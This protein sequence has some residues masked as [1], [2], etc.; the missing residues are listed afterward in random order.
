MTHVWRASAARLRQAAISVGAVIALAVTGSAFAA[1]PVIAEKPDARRTVTPQDIMAL[2]DVSDPQISPDGR[3]VLYV[4][5]TRL[6]TGNPDR[7]EIRIAAVDRKR[8][9]DLPRRLTAGVSRE[10]SPRWSPDGSTI[11]FLSDLA[12]APDGAAL[13]AGGARQLWLVSRDGSAPRVLTRAKGG[14]RSF[15][16]SPDGGSIAF[17]SV[18]AAGQAPEQG[19]QANA[20]EAS[21]VGTVLDL[22][23]PFAR[24]WIKDLASGTERRIAVPGRHIA[25]L[26]WSPDARHFA[27]RAAASSG[28]NDHFYHSELLLLDARTGAVERKLSDSVYSTASWSPDGRL[29]AFTAPGPGPIGILAYIA[30]PATGQL[31]E[32]GQNFA[33]TVR[34]L[35]WS[36]KADTIIARVTMHTRQQ[37]FRVDPASGRFFPLV[38]FDGRI[39]DFSI[40]EDGTLAL[41]A[42]TPDRPADVWAGR[43]DRLR[44]ITD[45]NPQVR[46]LKLAKVSE[47]H[48]TSSQ[49]GRPIYGVQVLPPGYI[50]GRPAKTVVLAHGGPHDSWSAAWQGS[51]I[52]WAQILAARGYVILLPNPRGSAGQGTG[53]ARSVIDGWG[54]RDYQDIIDGV[55]LLVRRGIADPAHLGIGGW[56]Y[57]GYM[58]AWAMTHDTR[59]RTAVIG[60]APTDVL[61]LALS[62]DTPDFVTAYFGTL[63]QGVEEMD[64]AS[65]LRSLDRVTAPILVLHGEEDERVPLSQGRG[66][67]RGLRLMGKPATMVTYPREPHRIGEAAHQLDI[68][69]RVVAWF[70]E[71]L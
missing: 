21:H 27:V 59:F 58:S 37:L 20:S 23:G 34:Q 47:V 44:P 39:A 48:W 35:D 49:D 30:D 63:P 7:S 15:R 50:A 33:G 64:R 9:A 62:T 52:D 66:F 67:Y 24:L 38:P 53:F 8:R 61:T 1:P 19:E 12:P 11:A 60:A 16:W 69:Q 40:A 13:H 68:Q 57:G 31:R 46:Q 41:A 6:A 22:P 32:I 65:P 54:S 26:S 18:D 2:T 43:S 3:W 45:L 28:I 42:S 4:T 51:W 71:H 10:T 55:D 70:D 25:D 5:Q 56:S 29:L 17:L 36:A 14:V